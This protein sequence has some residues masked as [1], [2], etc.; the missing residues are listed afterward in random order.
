[1]ANRRKNQATS[2]N[3]SSQ[4]RIVGLLLVFILLLFAA[5]LLFG[6][7]ERGL[8]LVERAEAAGPL[9]VGLLWATVIGFGLLSVWAL[10]WLFGPRKNRPNRPVYNEAELGEVL[11]EASDRGVDTR[12]AQAELA[13]LEKRRDSTALYICV[14]G[15]ISSGKS[16]LIK[17]LLPGDAERIDSDVLG[18]TTIAAEHFQWTADAANDGNK[19]DG[20]QMILVDVPGLNDDDAELP[21]IAREEAQRAHIVL[22]LCDGDLTRSQWRELE[23]LAA[24]DKPLVIGLN[25]MDRYKGAER[26]EIRARIEGRLAALPLTVLPLTAEVI[27]G[28]TETLIRV[29]A[30]G[31]E[32]HIERA[33]EPQLEGLM[34]ALQQQ[35]QA[36]PLEKLRDKAVLLRAASRLE[37]A[38]SL[39][40]RERAEAIVRSN[41]RA[42]V[43]GALAAISP[44]SDLIIQGILATKMVR[45]LSTLHGLSV[46]EVEI[47]ELFKAANNRLSRS[48]ALILAIAGN[49]LKAFPG[50]GTI[51]GGLTHAVAYG[52][53]FDTFGHALARV[54][55]EKGRFDADAT[56]NRMDEMLEGDL[57]PRAKRIA[58]LAW[59]SRK[60]DK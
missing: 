14:F 25:K 54:L 6:A 1:M 52:M 16:S 32:S 37:I 22:Y 40:K 7:L 51:A 20:E 2:N 15:D 36:S 9:A 45:E 4:R 56:L 33:R 3:R 57:L 18:G 47:D 26:D 48:A 58:Q 23:Q 34:A 29:D 17:A 10:W 39:F 59:E 24:F 5:S 30:E 43:V 35:L 60:Q 50:I 53:L 11:V 19:S 44:G 41:T 55:D 21:E 31:N 42:A 28:G 12:A 38:E 13:E 27:T 49:G 8:L 46:R